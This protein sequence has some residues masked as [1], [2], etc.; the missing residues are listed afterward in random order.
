MTVTK[1]TEESGVGEGN[2]WYFFSLHDR[3]YTTGDRT[4][5]ATRSGYWKATG[6]DR[7]VLAAGAD[8]KVVGMRKTLVFYTGRA[9]KGRK[10]DWVMHE[11]RLHPR[12]KAAALISHRRHHHCDHLLIKEDWVLCRVFYR[13]RTTV[14]RPPPSQDQPSD[15]PSRDEPELPPPPAAAPSNSIA[16]L[17]AAYAFDGG[18]RTAA[19][20]VSCFSGVLPTVPFTRPVTLGDLLSIDTSEIE[21]MGIMIG[22]MGVTSMINSGLEVPPSWDQENA[23]AQV[24]KPL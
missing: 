11:F 8:E 17:I 21:A 13:S 5:R 9:P 15:M 20:Q 4:N 18:S 6:K 16:P 24:W 23:L 1:P 2:E 19:E 3:K 12:F 7:A 22:G 14:P 10:T